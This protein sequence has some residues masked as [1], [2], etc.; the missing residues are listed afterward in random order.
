MSFIINGVTVPDPAKEGVTITREPIW[1]TNTGRAASGKMVGDIKTRKTTIAVTWPPLSFADTNTI[2]NAIESGGPFFQ[3]SFDNDL[4]GNSR[5][6]WTVYASNIPRTIYSLSN[7]ARFHV[8][9]TVT[10][11]EQ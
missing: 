9:V 11:I 4:G 8:G 6:S 3:I 1:D 7:A 2:I 5:Q 10:F